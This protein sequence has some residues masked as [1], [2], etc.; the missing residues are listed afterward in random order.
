LPSFISSARSI[1][2][3]HWLMLGQY[4]KKEIPFHAGNRGRQ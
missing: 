4:L 2:D 3:R 1:K